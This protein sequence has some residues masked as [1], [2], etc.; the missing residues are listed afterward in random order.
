MN[1]NPLPNGESQAVLDAFWLKHIQ[2]RNQSNLS[3]TAYCKE[4][5][6]TYHK[7]LYREQ[8]FF[9]QPNVPIKLLP[10]HIA[11]SQVYQEP[12]SPIEELS[13]TAKA[14]ALC[15]LT[16]KTGA[17]LQIYDPAAL[18]TLIDILR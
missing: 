3:K 18:R 13:I 14:S 12:K 4:H 1:K 11:Q 6:L 17:V 8:K 16:L 5:G 2:Q 15:C 10:V 7:Y 9:S